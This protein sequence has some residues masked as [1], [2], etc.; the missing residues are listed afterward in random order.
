MATIN[1]SNALW[2]A[3]GAA[4]AAA[5][6]VIGLMAFRRRNGRWDHVPAPALKG[7]SVPGPVGASGNVRSA[8]TEEMRDPPRRWDKGDE[9]SDE[10]FP[11]SAPE[12]Y[13]PHND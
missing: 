9:A 3:I 13:K 11:A 2:A 1:R 7:D 12:N 8:G 5:A 10:S 6:G 4:G